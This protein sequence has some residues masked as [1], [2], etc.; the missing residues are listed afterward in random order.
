VALGATG[1]SHGVA[2]D[3]VP[4]TLRL[5]ELRDPPGFNPLISDNADLQDFVVLVHGFLL[6]ANARGEATPDLV[7]AV[8]TL[9]N[10]GLSRDGLTIRY[11]LRRGVRWQDGVPFDAR[12]VVFS[13]RAA[14]SPKNDVPDRSG[15]DDIA[16]VRAPSPYEV[17]VRLRRPYSPALATFFS[18]GANDP[19]AILPA[20]LLASLPDLNRA[21]YNALPIGLG[22]YRVVRWER[23]SRVVLEADPHYRFGAPKIARVEVRIVPDSN[24]ALTLWQANEL[25]VFPVRGFEG[26]RAMLEGARAVS[27]G[28]EFRSDHYQF[29]YVM[30]N[31]TAGALRD[32]RVRRAIVR[33][34]DGDRIEKLVRGELYRPGDGDRL[35]GQFAYDPAIRQASYD[36]AAAARLLD[37]A[38]WRMGP[39]GVRVH[40]G[41]PLSVEIVGISGSSGAE[42]FDVQLQAA[43]QA[44]G[45]RASLKNYQYD[46]AFDS[47]Q[48]GG[49]FASGKFGLALYG[50]QPGEDA[51]H[52]YLFRCDTRPPGGENYGRICDPIIDAAAKREIESTDPAVQAAADKDMLREIDARSDILFLG[53]DREAIFVRKTLTGVAPSVLGHHYW[54]LSRWEWR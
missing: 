53:F 18:D 12:D 26:S 40:D 1:C 11:R 48:N 31:V 6:G 45:I 19:Y 30:L 37:A 5:Y 20:H 7:E 4:G 29:N 16:S 46:I 2:N 27:F 51:D 14:M 22:P 3:H 28:R 34:V 32:E 15:F 13:F 8:P 49:I 38:G 54:N 25:D 24:T 35:P 17:E 33:G 39:G 23:G 50:W 52:S 10:G 21:A 41:V 43:L 47:A 36:P 9:A 42:R 44:L